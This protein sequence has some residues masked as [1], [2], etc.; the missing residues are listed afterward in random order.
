MQ[1]VIFSNHS[2]NQSINQLIKHIMFLFIIKRDNYVKMTRCNI[3]N[4][5]FCLIG[6]DTVDKV[7]LIQVS[8][9]A[10]LHMKP[11]CVTSEI[12]SLWI[13][14]RM[15]CAIITKKKINLPQTE[16]YTGFDRKIIINNHRNIGE[17]KPLLKARLLG[18][19]VNHTAVRY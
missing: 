18:I 1:E 19:A 16:I 14:T 15:Y 10:R 8:N 17:N 5:N 4:L 11:F 7:C 13:K 3:L 12:H 6:I 2:I 9:S